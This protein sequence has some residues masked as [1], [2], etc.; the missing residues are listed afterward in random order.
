[1]S[2]CELDREISVRIRK[3]SSSFRSLCRILWYQQKIMMSTKMR[4]FKA[5][6][7][8]T[9]LYG[10][11]TWTPLAKQMKRLQRF[12]MR[13]L[14]IILGVS[15]REKQRNTDIRAKANIET[16]ETMV[17][18]RKLRWLGHVARM[19][20]GRI[21]RQL[22]VCRPETG[23]HTAGGQKLRWADIVTKDLKRCKINKDW[24][25]IAQDRDE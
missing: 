15:M 16:V 22:L 24:R 8:P 18:K 12:V 2:D 25:K 3:A 23:K 14:R 11:E 21:P 5:A 7:L 6:I 1:M 4:M 17:R 20:A 13:C 9:L 10:S 19:D